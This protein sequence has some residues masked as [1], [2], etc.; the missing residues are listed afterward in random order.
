MHRD[1][2]RSE[3]VEVVCVEALLPFLF[4]AYGAFAVHAYWVKR[5]EF[6]EGFVSMV[7]KEIIVWVFDKS[8]AVLLEMHVLEFEILKWLPGAQERQTDYQYVLQFPPL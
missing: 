2:L 1:R 8:L 4:V 6:V 3:S 7:L 5:I